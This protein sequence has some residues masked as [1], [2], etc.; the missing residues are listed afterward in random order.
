MSSSICF[1][2]EFELSPSPCDR[3]S[4]I[5]RRIVR[6]WGCACLTPGYIQMKN[7]LSSSWGRCALR[8][9]D[10][11]VGDPL[12]H[13]RHVVVIDRRGPW[14]QACWSTPF[15]R[16]VARCSDAGGQAESHIFSNSALYDGEPGMNPLVRIGV[17]IDARVVSSELLSSRQSHAR[18]GRR[19]ACRPDA[20]F[21][22]QY[23]E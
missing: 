12:V 8:I 23:V 7:G 14:W 20:T 19:L 4:E 22:R 18:S 9:G 11:V 17:G 2:R 5:W 1:M 10:D 6:Q 3:L 16:G 13:R 21:P 15:R